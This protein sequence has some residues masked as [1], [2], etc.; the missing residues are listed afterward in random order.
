MSPIKFNREPIH[1]VVSNS[2]ATHTAGLAIGVL[3]VPI[4]FK[5]MSFNFDRIPID[6]NGVL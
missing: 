4:G 6:Y 1:S 5:R 2:K 3:F